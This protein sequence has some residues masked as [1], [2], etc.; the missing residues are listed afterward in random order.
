MF[1]ITG[2][3]IAN[4]ND[5]DLRE[6]VG[7]LCEAD[8]R[9]AGLPATWVTWGGHQNAADD[10]ID[11]WF[12]AD[13][14]TGFEHIGN[15]PRAVTGFQVKKPDMPRHKILKEMQPEG[16]LRPVIREL[17]DKSGAYII[18][19]GVASATKK[20]LNNR[21]K[22]MHEATSDLDN[23]ENLK[24]IFY[25]QVRIATW[26]RYHPSLV[27]WVR[28][29]IGS[30]IQGW[31]PFG[32]WTN[33]P[34]EI[35]EE[36][37]LDDKIVIEDGTRSD[38]HGM[39]ATAGINSLRNKLRCPGSSVRL[40][41]LSG[42]GKTRLL[43]A[44]FDE[45]I[46][47]TSLN[48]SQ[49]VYT[50]VSDAPTPAPCDCATQLIE[51]GQPTILAI[52]NC[53]PDLHRRLTSICTAS[54]SPISLITVE[55]DVREDLPEKTEVFHL[56][57]ASISVVERIIQ[58]RFKNLGQS[59]ARRIA[60][61]S[62]GN[63]LLALCLAETVG[64]GE[65]LA[66]LR[67][68]VLFRRLFHQRNRPDEMLL[69]SAEVCSLVYSFDGEI[70]GDKI[71]ELEI[72]GSLVDINT[73]ELYRNIA[74][75][76]RRKL[77]QSRNIWR[78]VLP[79]ALANWLAQQA[80]E[81]IPYKTIL[82]A[83]E[84]KNRE[85]LL[86]S[87]SRRLSYLHECETAQKIAS[88]WLEAGGMLG[89]VNNL[90]EFGLVL[91]KNI[92]PVD[93]EAT[94]DAIERAANGEDGEKF[95]SS[96]QN[97]RHPEL[98]QLLRM[99]AYDPKLFDKCTDLLCRFSF[100]KGPSGISNV[101]RDMLKYLFTII[102]SE[103][104]ASVEQR[105]CVVERLVESESVDEQ[106]I[107]ML[108]LEATLE[109]DDIISY[110][111]RHDFGA[112]PREDDYSTR[113]QKE[114]N[115]WFGAF[116]GLAEKLAVSERP[117]AVEAK[118]LL[119][120]KF[121]CVWINALVFEE[122]E[123]A[124]K[125]IVRKGPWN[126][127]WIAVLTIIRFDGKEMEQGV[128]MRCQELE[129]LLKPQTLLELARAYAFSGTRSH[130]LADAEAEE[131]GDI[132]SQHKQVEWHTKEIGKNVATSE[133]D[134]KA[135]LPEIV[136]CEADYLPYCFGCG[137]SKGCLDHMAMWKSFRDQL[138][139]VDDDRRISGALCG[140]LHTTSE[141]NP[142]VAESILDSAVNDDVFGASF[143]TLQMAVTIDEKGVERLEKSL[144]EGSA[145]SLIYGNLAF[146]RTHES[147]GDGHLCGLLR[148]IAAK[149]DGLRIAIEILR[150]RFHGTNGE[151]VGHSDE[152][153]A[154]GRHLL[155]QVVFEKEPDYQER[156]DCRLSKIADVC[157]V[158]GESDDT[159]KMLCDKLAKVFS[160]NNVST[161]K[162]KRLL[163]YLAR[164]Y[165][166]I[167]LDVFL[168][169]NTAIDYHIA[170]RFTRN[171]AHNPSPIMQIEEDIVVEW[172]EIA[173]QVRYPIM[174]ASIVPFWHSAD[175]KLDGKHLAMTIIDKTPDAIA[176]LE[177]FFEPYPSSIWCGSRVDVMNK[178]LIHISNLKSHENPIVS[179]WAS[180]KERVFERL[181]QDKKQQEKEYNRSRDERFE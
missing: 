106:E 173:P 169:H 116:I 91:F 83:F 177:I 120:G 10:G 41:G 123:K 49:V 43:Q 162:F 18:I 77:V 53:P 105:L 30:P 152:I 98:S 139:T 99:L 31:R 95:I 181:I 111:Q 107:G 80:L 69:R 172:C 3:D 146:G 127:G 156:L 128:L 101:A 79:H 104:K 171:L 180:E 130:A 11:V 135:L 17:A 64:P 92:A 85:R 26:V 150:M 75:L 176:V 154:V 8:L 24:L 145:P 109:T 68:D 51:L 126:E 94:L 47:T 74:K 13:T 60:A 136:S 161:G 103:T 179:K 90:S 50:D 174:A 42:V 122:L 6:L 117:I 12:E 20:T 23:A 148:M 164:K 61:F 133:E 86:K 100:S 170:R 142:K 56:D 65:S 158:D 115:E 57:T 38:C 1:E 7:L 32:N 141:T 33:A 34:G 54:G 81:N 55:Y 147:I 36:Y 2:D 9:A 70:D 132:S 62:G 59:N 168:G 102:Y 129:R 153:R 29:R 160:E 93:L 125:S 76:K 44:L 157:L 112:R 16:E 71:S 28:E 46:G 124:A 89:E 84:Q 121:R 40:T 110:S 167:F 114:V 72:L 163:E 149:P 131:D 82:R 63:A 166:K 151:D 35:D 4:L 97:D 118:K 159:A 66:T 134:F 25:D 19:S 22:A 5:S 143:P 14:P 67:D 119:A 52:D 58:N 178:M 87:F 175:G 21:H 48:R 96:C 140:F 138:A 108:L 155:G 39:E 27:R 144:K 15:I 113:T 73:T 78:A 165:S 137:L 37:Y 45:K 88:H